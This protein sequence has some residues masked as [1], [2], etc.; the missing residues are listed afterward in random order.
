MPATDASGSAIYA[1]ARERVM[2]LHG[3]RAHLVRAG[4][5]TAFRQPPGLAPSQGD[6]RGSLLLAPPED[7]VLPVSPRRR[8][9]LQ[10]HARRITSTPTAHGNAT[11]GVRVEV[12]GDGPALYRRG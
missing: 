10:R 7:E 2:L 11:R 4:N 5:G 3:A 9:T 1:A 12:R 8:P 6:E